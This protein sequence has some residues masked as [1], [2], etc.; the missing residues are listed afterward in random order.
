MNAKLTLSLDSKVI[1][2][3]KKLSKKKGTSLSK[4]VE[5]YL[6]QLDPLNTKGRKKSSIMELKGIL[7]AVPKDFDYREERYNHL[8]EKHK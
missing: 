2:S 1:E 7:G 8:M 5:N 6:R 3:A 4:L